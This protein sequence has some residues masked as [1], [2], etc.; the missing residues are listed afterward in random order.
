M[1]IHTH[2][3]LNTTAQEAE[4]ARASEGR[5]PRICE[6]AQTPVMASGEFAASQKSR[7]AMISL[8]TSPLAP[9]GRTRDA[10]GMN[11]YIRELARELGRSGVEID[12]FTRRIDCDTPTIQYP[13]HGV[14]LI[15]LPAGPA[16]LLPPSELHPYVAEF[17]CRL[18]HF[19]EREQRSY[20]LI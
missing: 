18:A 3:G 8:H 4:A 7:I 17:S 1:T 10:G 2:S 11:V 19:A 20:D 14:R 15:S 16:T 5:W 13:A 12:I 6:R 9:L